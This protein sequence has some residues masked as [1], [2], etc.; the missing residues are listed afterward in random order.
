MAG[1]WHGVPLRVLAP[2]V[3]HSYLP[4]DCHFF[5]RPCRFA[6]GVRLP[7]R[8]GGDVTDVARFIPSTIYFVEP[9]LLLFAVL[10]CHAA[11]RLASLTERPSP[12]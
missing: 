10:S 2:I 3:S 4:Q 6:W 5:N 8:D 1:P 12:A 9:A 7:E 11:R